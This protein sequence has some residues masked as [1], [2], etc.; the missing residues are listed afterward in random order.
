[1]TR[2]TDFDEYAEGYDAALDRG[3]SFSGEGK[4]YFAR[5]RIEWLG[6]CLKVLSECPRRIMDYGCGSGST[7]PLFFDVLGAEFVFG[8]D[9]SAKSL[10]L[11]RCS[12]AE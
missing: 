4:D 10:D 12:H 6:Q 5:R 9:V 7:T 11:A 3:I 2:P 1:M 8:L